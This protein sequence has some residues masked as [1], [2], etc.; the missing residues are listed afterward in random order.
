MR[1]MCL[2]CASRECL[3]ARIYMC[4]RAA[5]KKERELSKLRGAGIL[6]ENCGSLC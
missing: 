5:W 2:S 6:E 4:G 3:L 1:V